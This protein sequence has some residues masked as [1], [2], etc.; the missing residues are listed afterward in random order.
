LRDDSFCRLLRQSKTPEDILQLLD[1]A[2]SSQFG[3]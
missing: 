1:E 2:D 3:S